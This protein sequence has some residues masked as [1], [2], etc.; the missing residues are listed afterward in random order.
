MRILICGAGK[1]G[2]HFIE[3]YMKQNHEIIVI[4]KQ[5]QAI[6]RINNLFDVQ[7]ITGDALLPQ[8]LS[9]IDMENIGIVVA[10]THDDNTNLIICKLSKVLSPNSK[11]I[12]RI[13]NTDDEYNV[14]YEEMSVES[15]FFPERDIAISLYNAIYEAI[16]LPECNFQINIEEIDEEIHKKNLT[17]WVIIGDSV[18]PYSDENLAQ[19]KNILFIN[20]KNTEYT[21]NNYIIIGGNLTGSILASKLLSNGCKVTI[22]EPNDKTAAEASFKFPNT[23]IIHGSPFERRILLEAKLDEK[24]TIVTTT[25]N[26]QINLITLLLA[27][28]MKCENTFGI[29]N[30]HNS[31]V[32]IANSVNIRNVRNIISAFSTPSTMFSGISN[33]TKL[34]HS[35]LFS[36][37]L[38]KIVSEK[39]IT[40]IES[41]NWSQLLIIRKGKIIL[42]QDTELLINDN[43][44]VTTQD[45]INS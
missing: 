14:L 16:P 41:K 2:R 20:N 5:K 32:D 44:V 34:Y 13:H 21:K 10:A 35:Q 9:K 23:E 42:S 4:D 11:N 29:I 15:V 33:I 3:C 36:I 24:S 27:K 45:C 40:L 26:D 7:T 12:A 22:I 38:V 1:I 25:E 31:Y 39:S 18:L 30:S 6:D 17:P 19:G 37:Y 8:V 28:S 43:V